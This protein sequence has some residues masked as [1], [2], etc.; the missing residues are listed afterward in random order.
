MT[1]R[2]TKLCANEKMAIQI[3]EFI[4]RG[5]EKNY[6][7]GGVKKYTEALQMGIDALTE[8]NRQRAEIESLQNHFVDVNK[9]VKSG[10]I[11]E[12][13]G[14]LKNYCDKELYF[15]S[16]ADEYAFE[17]YGDGLVK[18]MEETMNA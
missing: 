15:D 5:Y 6:Q 18:E 16:S 2:E 9:M 4:K 13:W 3:L 8:V 10:A 17:R 11:K 14:K 1:Y 7:D 12:F